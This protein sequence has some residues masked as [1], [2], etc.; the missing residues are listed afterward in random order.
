MRRYFYLSGFALILSALITFLSISCGNNNPSGPGQNEATATPTGTSTATSTPTK[1]PTPTATRTP[2]I[3]PTITHT[4]YCTSPSSYGVTTVLSSF[5]GGATYLKA[6]KVVL[7]SS[8]VAVSI[9][10]YVGSSGSQLIMGIY[11]D[12]GNR[13]YNLISQ[14]TARNIVYNSW[15][16]VALPNVSL[17]TGTY[18]L[19]FFVSAQTNASNNYQVGVGTQFYNTY[20]WGPMPATIAGGEGIV[21]TNYTDAININTCP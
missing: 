1:T 21:R 5:G 15:N 9:S 12:S 14:T 6:D 8:A 18:W 20:P 2:T 13:P 10:L 16:T 11:G 19:A 17:L 4:P 7:S 3:T